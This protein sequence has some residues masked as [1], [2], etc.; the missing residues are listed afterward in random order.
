[1]I[2]WSKAERYIANANAWHGNPQRATDLRAIAKPLRRWLKSH[3]PIIDE[4]GLDDD[5]SEVW[6][7]CEQVKEA[8]RKCGEPGETI[9][10]LD[11]P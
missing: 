8:L 10:N 1:M 11:G 7:S 9:R 3:Q 2:S 5:T 4:H 6:Q